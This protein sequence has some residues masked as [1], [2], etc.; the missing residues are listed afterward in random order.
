MNKMLLIVLPAVLT[1]LLSGCAQLVTKQYGANKGGTVK[2]NKE[3][4]MTEKNRKKA[5][6]VANDYC[7]PGRATILSE[8]ERVESNG[9]SS[10][11]TRHKGSKSYSSTRESRSATIYMNFRCRGGRANS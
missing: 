1:V 6:T 2:Y 8:E 7:A 11:E 10:T 9:Y 5:V 4:F 3:L